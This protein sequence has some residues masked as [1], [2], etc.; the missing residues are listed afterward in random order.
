MQLFARDIMTSPVIAARPGARVK[1]LVALM[2]ANRISGIPI[3]AADHELVG[4]VTEADI[5]YKEV[6]PKPHTPAPL[7]RRCIGPA[8]PRQPSGP[9]RPRACVPTKS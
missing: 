4:I 6:Q 3:V 8:P 1:D 5:L 7:A 2:T 9:A